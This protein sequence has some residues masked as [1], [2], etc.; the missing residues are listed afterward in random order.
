EEDWSVDMLHRLLDLLCATNSG[1]SEGQLFPPNSDMSSLPDP[2]ELYFMDEFSSFTTATGTQNTTRL[3]APETL[4]SSP[5]VGETELD[6][7]TSEIPGESV[8]ASA[9]GLWSV[10]GPAEQLFQKQREKLRTSAAYCSMIRGASRFKSPNRALQLADEAWAMNE[11][12]ACLDAT[13]YSSLVR[14]LSHLDE[15]NIWPLARSILDRFVSSEQPPTVELF[16][17]TLSA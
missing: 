13:T 8:E 10:H 9:I 7:E 6:P 15:P 14:S 11:G 1:L 2:E 16:S 17:S 3:S 4:D 12:D 5:K